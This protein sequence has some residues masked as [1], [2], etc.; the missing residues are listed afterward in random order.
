MSETRFIAKFHLRQKTIL[1]CRM[2]NSAFNEFS[3]NAKLDLYPEK[4][5]KKIDETIKWINE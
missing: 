1:I 4:E 2:F 3:S 5:R